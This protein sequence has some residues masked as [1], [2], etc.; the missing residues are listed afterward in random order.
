MSVSNIIP[1]EILA[2]T[3]CSFCGFFSPESSNLA[4]MN[5]Y[6]YKFILSQRINGIIYGKTIELSDRQL[7]CITT[8][9]EN[10]ENNLSMQQLRTN[11]RKISIQ[12][13]IKNNCYEIL[14]SLV[15]SHFLMDLYEQLKDLFS[16]NNNLNE[17]SIT[18][19]IVYSHNRGE[20]AHSQIIDL[21]KIYPAIKCYFKL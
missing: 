5:K 16:Q 21:V 20:L 15:A 1:K 9:I 2:E 6:C 4:L 19:F 18:N 3:I 11:L 8:I 14:K 12:I 13:L 7:T 10:K 17:S